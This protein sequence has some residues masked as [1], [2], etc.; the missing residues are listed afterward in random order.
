MTN[1]RKGVDGEE[2]EAVTKNSSAVVA[3]TDR[4]GRKVPPTKTNLC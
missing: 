1:D 4:T 3:T 2:K